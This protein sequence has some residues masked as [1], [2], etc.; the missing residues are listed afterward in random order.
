M[1]FSCINNACLVMRNII[2]LLLLLLFRG[3]NNL[4]NWV[5]PQFKAHPR[6]LRLFQTK[7]SLS[8]IPYLICM[9]AGKKNRES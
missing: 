3:K 2:L 7:F 1:F 8:R 9:I 6:S 4:K 5:E